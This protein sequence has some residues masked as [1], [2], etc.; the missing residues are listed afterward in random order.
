MQIPEISV[1]IPV[2]NAAPFL[3]ESIESI[4]NQTF[5]DF[6]LII[7]NDK[8]TDESLE[9]IK[10][11]QSKDNR[12]I[13]IDKEQNV[14]PANLRNEG[15]NAARGTFI[16][17]MDA[18]DIALPTRFEKQIAILKNNP[19]IGVCGTG[20][21]FFGSKKNKTINH[22]NDHDAIKVS[23]LHSCNIGNPT[24][25]FKKEVLGDLK[26]DNDYVPAEDYDLW[27]RLLAKTH[28]YNIPE[29]LLNYRQHDNNISK[30][31]ID[32]VN[33]SVKRVKIKQ[34]AALEVDP[35]DPKIDFYLNAVSLQ[36]KLSPDEIIE[37]INASKF[38]L[39]QNEKI[40]YFNQNLLKKHIDKV[41]VRTIRN[42]GS[43]NIA[44][45]KHLSKK[46]KALF[47]K[48]S[49]FDRTILYFK[50]LFGR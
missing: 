29:S 38:L 9:I 18:D 32:N 30:T 15:I 1:I 40:Q 39:S 4:L 3:Q 35:A 49:L 46:E 19:E 44:F 48:I 31:K 12:V 16:A 37:T 2:F 5:S 43:F 45:Y 13:I 6:E 17:L 50:S 8:S 20:F 34:L 23:F 28:F 41:L 36:K 10:K 11:N 47:Q 25:M 22:S 7:L 42:A 26:F 21:T 14:G 33:R 24:V 27:S